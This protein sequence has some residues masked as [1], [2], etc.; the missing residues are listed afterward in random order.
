M[1]DAK[2]LPGSSASSA[3]STALSTP[4][5]PWFLGQADVA[6][7]DGSLDSIEVERPFDGGLLGRVPQSSDVDVER[8]F[9]AARNA[10]IGWAALPLRQRRQV[11]RRFSSLLLRHQDELLDLVQLETGKSRTDA[12]EEVI[13]ASLW[14]NY[15]YHNAEK[16]L[17]A[18]RHRG[19]LPGLTRT[20][21]HRVPKGI[22]GVIT[23]WNY[24][25]TLPATDALPAL[26]AGN[27]VVLKPDSA[28]PYSAV[29][30]AALL[31]QAGLPPGLLQVVIG[32]G[33]RVGEAVVAQ[34]DFV[35]FTGSS[36]TGSRIAE[37]C[38]RRLVGFSGELG[39]KN[40]LL[41]LADTDPDTAAEGAVQACFSN[42]GQLCISAERVFVATEVWDSF[43]QSFTKRVQDLKLAPSYGWQ[44]D[45]GSLIG[46]AQLARVSAHVDEA[47]ELGAKVLVGGTARPD[48]G[49]YFFEP[50]VLTG[51]TPAMHV[52]GEETFG[53]VVSL[54]RVDSESEA[55]RQAN[56]SPYGLNASVW[57]RRRGK[58][59]APRV[60]AGTV[61]VNDG[62]AAAW[63]SYG[64]PMGG[65]GISGVG[66]RHGAEGLQKYTEPQTIA[67]QRGLRIAGPAGF[68][69]QTWA[70]IMRTGAKALRYLP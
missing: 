57:S 67:L 22:V 40:P 68:D 10:Q 13:D 2:H 7:S 63:G 55:V 56:A 49:P 69:K 47:R 5:I 4:E 6:V 61:N 37:V 26:I 11:A 45:V 36:A 12:F 17:R 16:H 52:Y 28:T 38:G 54:Y 44:S 66:R 62:Y 3:L 8:A 48:L 46:P 60:R 21:T 14:A 15:V 23:P 30:V 41:V 24:P 34:A 25:L 39:G 33:A 53:P 35:M 50:T 31:R 32:P 1:T 19:A 58:A 29:A 64:A 42:A 70:Q 20:H 18:E 9:A 51:V 27:A 65:M 43:V 59:V